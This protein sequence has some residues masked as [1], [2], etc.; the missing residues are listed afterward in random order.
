MENNLRDLYTI[1]ARQPKVQNKSGLVDFDL[2]R[3]DIFSYEKWVF[4]LF[5]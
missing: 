2:G 5:Y 3:T 4:S 1:Y